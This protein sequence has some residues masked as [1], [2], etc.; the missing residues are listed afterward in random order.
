MALCANEDVDI[1]SRYDEKHVHYGAVFVD[2]R[3][4]L[5][6]TKHESS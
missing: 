4:L 5:K 3:K 2:Y 6:I 1:F